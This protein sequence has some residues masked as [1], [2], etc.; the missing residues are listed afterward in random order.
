[1]GLL[2]SFNALPSLC[3]SNAI[4][5]ISLDSVFVPCFK[6]NA[7]YT[8]PVGEKPHM[9]A[10]HKLLVITCKHSNYIFLI[11]YIFSY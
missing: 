9:I 7:G 5:F 2:I 1:V 11:R 8:D 3:E 4:D 6:L 10:W